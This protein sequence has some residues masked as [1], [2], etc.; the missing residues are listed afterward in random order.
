MN[1]HKIEKLF[2]KL[3]MQYKRTAFEYCEFDLQSEEAFELARRGAPKAKI[4]GSQIVYGLELKRF[5]SPFMTV[6]FQ[7]IGET[8]YFL[9]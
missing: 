2:A 8:D 9:R 4:P 5:R 7:L 3:Q 6:R 1:Q